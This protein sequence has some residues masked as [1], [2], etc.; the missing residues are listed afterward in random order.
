M[1]IDKKIICIYINMY[2]Y[3]DDYIY[4]VYNII[5]Y[6]HIRNLNGSTF[7]VNLRC[8]SST[9]KQNTV[10]QPALEFI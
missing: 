2:Y 1:D 4:T 7:N 3:D 9:I 6:I 10:H 5:I 8:L